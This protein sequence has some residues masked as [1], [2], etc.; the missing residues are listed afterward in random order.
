MLIAIFV[1][2]QISSLPAEGETYVA[3]INGPDFQGTNAV[4]INV[5]PQ[6]FIVALLNQSHDV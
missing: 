3:P 5:Q 1:G 6:V 2:Q 4:G